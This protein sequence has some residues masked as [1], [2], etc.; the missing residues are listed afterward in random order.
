MYTDMYDTFDDKSIPY[1]Y[2]F[3]FQGNKLDYMEG[4]STPTYVMDIGDSVTLPFKIDEQYK[5]YKIIL[6]IYNFRFEEIYT[7]DFLVA[8]DGKIYFVVNSELSK[9][10]FRHGRY[11]CRLQA[12]LKDEF[13]EDT[14]TLIRPEDCIIYVR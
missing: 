5:E 11:Y 9:K 10:L 8:P 12:S 13:Y 1:C 3:S 2:P 4:N 14:C 7:E 6:T